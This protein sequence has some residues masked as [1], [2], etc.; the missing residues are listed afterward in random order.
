VTALDIQALAGMNTSGTVFYKALCERT[1][2]LNM[3]AV[4]AAK[5]HDDA[6]KIAADMENVRRSASR[7]ESL[8]DRLDEYT[9]RIE[10]SLS[11]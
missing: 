9:R 11:H 8:V 7:L 1:E 3:A 5:H 4:A 10:S 2:A 6:R